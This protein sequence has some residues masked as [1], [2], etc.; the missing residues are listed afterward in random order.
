[1]SMQNRLRIGNKTDNS[2][3]FTFTVKGRDSSG[4]GADPQNSYNSRSDRIPSHRQNAS[5]QVEE[6]VGQSVPN[7]LSS[8]PKIKQAIAQGK[9]AQFLSK[10]NT[11]SNS[12]QHSRK[13]TAYLLDASTAADNASMLSDS[14]SR[15]MTKPSPHAKPQIN[16]PSKVL[17]SRQLDPHFA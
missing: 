3:R 14:N 13:P 16:T 15:R 6:S 1:M 9:Y 10:Q 11:A 4:R 2:C 5:N 7:S 8:L 12:L 17:S